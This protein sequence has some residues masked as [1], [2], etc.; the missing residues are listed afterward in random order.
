M[1][2]QVSVG[3]KLTGDAKTFKQASEE[4]RKSTQALA[5]ANKPLRRQLLDVRRE[6]QKM[7][8]A[9]DTSSASY[10]QMRAEAAGLQDSLDRVQTE[11]KIFADDALV[12]N[13]VTDAFQGMTGAMQMTQGIS[14][15]LGTENEK[16]M[17]TF[18]KL[19]ALQS[20]SNGLQQVSNMLQKESRIV[21]LG[22]MA[23]VK[24]ATAAQWLWNAAMTANPIG[25]IIAGVA[26]LAGGIYAL[27][28]NFESVTNAVRQA[29]NWLM[30]W[31]KSTDDASDATARLTYSVNALTAANKRAERALAI[32][33][34]R[35]QFEIRLLR[36]MGV[37]AD[38]ILLKEKELLQLELERAR[39]AEKGTYGHAR[40]EATN[41]II[42]AERN[43][44]IVNEQIALIERTRAE[45]REAEHKKHIERLRELRNKELSTYKDIEVALDDLEIQFDELSKTAERAG[46]KFGLTIFGD[47]Y[48][49]NSDLQETNMILAELQ[50]S[51]RALFAATGDGFKGMADAFINAIKRMAAEAMAKMAVFF[52]LSALTGG[53]GAAAGWAGQALKGRNLKQFLGFASPMATG[54]IVPSGYPNDSYP[55]LLSSGEKVVPPGK[56]TGGKVV[57][58]FG[59]ARVRGRDILLSVRRTVIEEEATT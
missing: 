54:G 31:K 3:I 38:K 8:H 27:V 41:R 29:A 16:L 53:T 59:E 2:R 32:K 46:D 40:V 51:F 19:Q 15:L 6:M 7:A 9:G 52:L 13:T 1:S 56:L 5:N 39:E 14:A 20:V 4:A 58:E 42:D 45:A 28:R 12:L 11:I 43:L 21:V 49:F 55:A 47:L 26:A 57:V 30:F 36:A 18:V 37:E 44:A 33:S 25:L 22:K 10:K 48:R 35:L 34:D 23:A 17:Q 50:T 24:V